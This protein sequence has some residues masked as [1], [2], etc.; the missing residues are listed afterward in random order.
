MLK[1]RVLTAIAAL[2]VVAIAL[3]VLPQWATRVIISAL[4]LLA[5]WEW[6]GLLRIASPLQRSAYVALIGGLMAALVLILPEAVPAKRVFGIAMA[7]WV[8]A[9]AWLFFHPKAIST[10][11][12]ATCG[13]LV[14]VPA[15]FSVDWL[16]RFSNLSLLT[17]L[18]IVVVADSGAYFAGKFFGR[19][20]LA[21][22]ISPGKT[23][24]GVIG[25]LFAV[26]IAGIAVALNTG[27]SARV[28]LPLF[29]VVAIFSIVGD[30]TVS[31]F[32]R[33]AGVKDSGKLFP[34]HGGV[35]DRIDSI[36]AAAPAFALAI[37]LGAVT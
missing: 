16:Y 12:A 17:V 36:S 2:I 31:V 6:S 34:G 23:W 35:L 9:F 24:E 15:W 3:F 30:L 27:Q 7:W 19:V 13:A 5:A 25:G 18:L 10:A 4:M 20:K 8:I 29:V 28:L 26:V 33:N 11:L 37:V 22:A 14:I 21:P 32:K 1:Q